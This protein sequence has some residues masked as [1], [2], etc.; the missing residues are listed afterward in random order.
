MRNPEL[1]EE[2]TQAVFIILARKAGSLSFKTV[3][4][5]WLHRTTRYVAANTLHSEFRRQRREREAGMESM[6]Q[7]QPSDSVWQR[8]SPHLDEALTRLG[9]KDRDALILRYFQ[10][11]S[12][13]EVGVELGMKDRAAQK[14]ILRALGKLR[15]FLV[16]RGLNL[17]V[18]ALAGAIAANSLQAAPDGLA[19]KIT[20]TVAT[21]S[22]VAAS[23]ST[24]VKGALNLMRI[25]RLKAAA[26][27]GAAAIILTGTSLVAYKVAGQSVGGGAV[28]DDSAWVRLTVPALDALPPAF[29]LRPTHFSRPVNNGRV[30]MGGGGGWGFDGRGIVIS[31]NKMIGKALTFDALMSLAYG[32]D[33]SLQSHHMANQ[34]ASLTC[35]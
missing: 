2:V 16:R 6:V 17:T 33:P 30:S 8:I 14:V 13:G 21:G 9:R 27:V 22:T 5:G 1:A 19:A 31:G 23:T 3:L 10:C 20:V 15:R 32:V 34:P 35:Y 11:K 12:L 4:C 25:A 26:I 28:V 18:T 29:V 24:L 7:S